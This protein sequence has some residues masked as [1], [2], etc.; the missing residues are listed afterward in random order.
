MYQA[1]I[2]D[3]SLQLIECHTNSL[4]SVVDWSG[5]YLI[6]VDKYHTVRRHIARARAFAKSYLTSNNEPRL[7]IITA[8]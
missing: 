6:E 8:Q 2:Y 3:L 4:P 1:C 7:L 5:K